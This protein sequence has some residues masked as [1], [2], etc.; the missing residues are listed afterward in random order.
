MKHILEEVLALMAQEEHAYG[1]TAEFFSTQ[2]NN[3]LA[4]GAINCIKHSLNEPCPYTRRHHLI[5]AAARIL[6]QIRVIELSDHYL[7]HDHEK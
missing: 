5:Y 6:V 4:K 3:S 2:T 7:L 1:L